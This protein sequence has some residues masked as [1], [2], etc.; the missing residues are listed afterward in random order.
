MTELLLIGSLLGLA[1]AV[2][3]AVARAQRRR[4]PGD[5]VLER[6]AALVAKAARRHL[7]RQMLVVTAIAAALGAVLFLLYGVAYQTTAAGAEAGAGLPGVPGP[8]AHG[9]W[10]LA[11]YALGVGCAL[12]VGH[13]SAVIGARATVQVAEGAR[14]SLDEPLELAVRAGAIAGAVAGVLAVGGLALLFFAHYLVAG[15]FGADSARA[16]ATT[17]AI[18]VLAVGFGLG[19]ALVAFLGLLG[20]GLFG[21]VADLGADVA[22]KLEANLPADSVQNPGTVADLAGDL[23]HD[24]A[25]RATAMFACNAVEL[26][27]AM[28][29][30]ADLYRSNRDLP[31]P[32]ALVLFP[33]VARA[34]GILAS[35]FG[36]M[37]VR[38]DDREVPMNALARGLVI[39]LLLYAAAVSGCAKWLLGEHWLRFALC[40]VL[41]AGA[42]LLCLASVHYH[43]ADRYAPVRSLA[44]AARGGAV[45]SA[46]RGLGGALQGAVVLGAVLGGAALGAARLGSSTGLEGGGAFGLALALVGVLGAAPYVLGM[47]VMG[48]VVDAGGGIVEMT[49]A[50]HRPDLRARA[51]VLDSV[52]N[53]GKAYAS[54][55]VSAGFALGGALLVQ[56]LT[57]AAHLRDAAAT[58]VSPPASHVAAFA[59][60]V[61]VTCFVWAT[62]GRVVQAS[63]ELIYD[64]RRELASRA[65]EGLE[66]QL[67]D[68][69]SHQERDTPSPIGARTGGAGADELHRGGPPD[70][71]ADPARAE[72]ADAP[73]A[74]G[75]RGAAGTGAQRRDDLVCAEMVS[76]LALRG[77]LPPAALGLGLPL[78]LLVALRLAGRGS[79]GVT[80]GVV[81]TFL[82]VATALAAGL[83]VVFASFGCA[84]DNAKRYI[85]TGA[86]GGRF[87]VEPA[88][89]AERPGARRNVNNPTYVAAAVGDAIGDPLKGLVGP[90]LSALAA[91][92]CCLALVVLPLFV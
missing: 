88:M 17:P 74:P 22:G 68:V 63:R 40:A 44:E 28:A 23:V 2:A 25:S 31:S 18:P 46:L 61:V 26:L 34:F 81:A 14:R 54:V 41:G 59:A 43:S 32:T 52:G 36:A 85:E 19:A 1:A 10:M 37:V 9:A 45:L 21:K 55:L 83:A 62:L 78:A 53:T 50:E 67:P 89:V 42:A 84:L 73:R 90:A 48:S 33:L 3:L 66:A 69:R 86:H 72:L 47:A 16:L 5:P 75:P 35:W 11:A 92:L 51:A 87:L 24:T 70:L 80:V 56:S 49:V 29:V 79:P 71:A 91:L 57:Q 4:L 39:A 6:T 58:A 76:R 27:G 60:V 30:A 8:R 38:T 15:R 82:V 65:A 77:L 7:R 12:L 13:L 64:L 20:G